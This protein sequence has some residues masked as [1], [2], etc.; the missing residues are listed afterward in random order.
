MKYLIF[1][2]FFSILSWFPSKDTP[3]E[4]IAIVPLAGIGFDK[5]EVK[6]V[7]DSLGRFFIQIPQL[8]VQRWDTLAQTKFWRT[9]IKLSPDSGIINISSSRQIIELFSNS[10]WEKQSPEKK[11]AYRDSVRRV[12]NLGI[13]DKIFF[14]RG[15]GDFYDFEGAI[16]TIDKG[17]FIF[18]QEKT[19]PFFAQTILLIESP[20]KCAKSNVGACGSFQLMKSVAIQMGM[21]VNSVVDERTDFDKSAAASAKLIRTVCIPQAKDILLRHNISYNETDLWFRLLVLH[22]YHAGA[23]NVSGAVNII[24]PLTGDMNLI[25]QLWQTKYKGFGNASQNYSQVALASLL[26]LD[27]IIYNKC[28]DVLFHPLIYK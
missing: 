19:D 20:G 28:E 18:E 13:E 24:Q 5:M 26:E 21:K 27:H 25:T 15:K 10:G 17:I 12:H 6:N 7:N 2:P 16:Q 3:T 1:L 23:G 14:S 9:L 4:P 22:I 8:Y 11:E